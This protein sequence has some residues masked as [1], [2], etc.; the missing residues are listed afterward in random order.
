MAIIHDL[1]LSGGVTIPNAY[2]RIERVSLYAPREGGNFGVEVAIYKDE[3]ARNNA[4]QSPISCETQ[5]LP[6][7]PTRDANLIEYAYNELKKL[8]AY[9]GAEDA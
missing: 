2:H 9:E 3:T 7:P 8:P 6:V 1:E 5:Q 4:E